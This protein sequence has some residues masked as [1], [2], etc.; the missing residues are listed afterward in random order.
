MRA[1][2]TP[3][4]SSGAETRPQRRRNACA[5]S[6][7]AFRR[8][9]RDHGPV[10]TVPGSST[11]LAFR[12]LGPLQVVG[13]AGPV[14]VRGRRQRAL[15][16]VLLLNAGRVVSTDRLVHELWG[17]RPPAT[18]P[19]SLRNL[20]AELRKAL[21]PEAIVRR[22]PGYLLDVDADQVDVSAF[23]RLLARARGAAPAERLELLSEALGLWRGPALADVAYEPFAQRE[24][25]RL[26]E[27]R[28]VALEERLEAELV[29]DLE[30]LVSEHPLRERFRSMLM[31]ALYR[32]GRQADALEVYRQAR[33]ALREGLGVDPGP[34]LEQR[35]RSILRQEP[36]LEP[37]VARKG[38]LPVQPTPFL[39]RKRE[40]QEV[41]ALL[42]RD[43]VRLLTLT[44]PGGSGKTRLVLAA[45]AELEDAYEDG[46]WWVPLAP[47]AEPALVLETIAQTLDAK[48]PLE[49]HLLHREVLVVM[50]NFEHLLEAA[51]AVAELLASCPYLKLVATSREPLRVSAEHEYRVP[52]LAEAEA[53]ELFGTRAQGAAAEPTA[54]EIC[55]RLDCL[56]LAIELAA[57][58]TRL[59]S[60]EA[61]LARL[62]RRLP[63]LTGGPRDAPERQ[64]TLEAAIGWSY[65]LLAERER[66]L[67]ARLA[68][69]AG[70]FALE[71][72]EAVCDADLDGMQSLVDKNL[73]RREDSRY[74]ML[75]TIREY[76]LAR[77]EESGDADEARR[78]HAERLLERAQ[79][80]A[81]ARERGGHVDLALL[82]KEVH[83]VRAAIRSALDRKEPIALRLANALAWFWS[84]SG[85]QAEG[86]RWLAEALD[87]ALDV[88]I[89]VRR[90]ALTAAA[91]L[92]CFAAAP[93]QVRRFGEEALLL[94]RAAGDDDQVAEALRWLGE[95]HALAGDL[96]QARAF[97]TESIT[98]RERLED[99]VRLARTVAS[100]ADVE[101]DAGQ[102]ETAARLF[103]QT[104]DLQRAAGATADAASTLHSLAD[105][106]LVRGDA[107]DAARLY[108][109]ALDAVGGERSA[110]LWC[111]AGLAAAAAVELRVERAG[112]L[113][114]AVEAD[115]QRRGVQ[116]QPATIRRRYEHL[117]ER[118]AG[119]ELAAAVAAGRELALE[120]AIEEACA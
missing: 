38:M 21:G 92:A 31:L 114:G 33:A 71:A 97:L 39:G 44:G 88:P 46:V 37:A 5:R 93:E 85:R 105:V 94:H 54:L 61:L 22:P 35:Y 18:A 1:T 52:G 89:S 14:E 2:D 16:A 69:F 120:Q 87:A 9:G 6:P 83:D 90:D 113:W 80:F 36:S 47:L 76:A 53:V 24:V 45:A 78:R 103:E 29:P 106:A 42:R 59:L 58:R 111:L 56:P 84:A 68:V 28:R 108:V 7:L 77:L 66:R 51:P 63:L 60:P 99:P 40:L 110:A 72:A 118:V 4:P 10:E 117:L 98:L 104:L 3:A 74:A 67:F 15:L 70:T 13:E 41:L 55:R 57:A 101:L 50:D 64:R 109:E 26:E 25:A 8:G 79:A 95:G 20:I 107:A 43:D 30:A 34:E 23:E 73:I 11:R 112:R 62:D 86:V 96:P 27:L 115:E 17:E 65:A 102:P 19:A 82:E 119:P 49:Q 100:L 91:A 81:A 12:L 75:E 48:Q 32:T 116:V